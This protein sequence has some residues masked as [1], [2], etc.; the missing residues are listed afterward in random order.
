MNPHNEPVHRTDDQQITLR[1]P[2]E[3]ADALPYMMG[4]HPPTPS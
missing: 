4:F 3:L 2:A 1:G